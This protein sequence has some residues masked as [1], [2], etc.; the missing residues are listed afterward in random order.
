[1][2]ELVKEFLAASSRVV[3]GERENIRS[4]WGK[5]AHLPYKLVLSF[6]FAPWTLVKFV[7]SSS[8]PPLKRGVAALGIAVAGLI[9][10]VAGSLFGRF[11]VALWIA[12]SFGPFIAIIIFFGTFAML[13]VLILFY[14][15]VF[16]FVCFFFLGLTKDEVIEHMR[17]LGRIKPQADAET[18]L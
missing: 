16:N 11:A 10:Y 6:V 2:F 1:M 17:D 18:K 8:C 7:I 5:I 3:V 4:A 9:T 12:G 14:L 15:A 13:L